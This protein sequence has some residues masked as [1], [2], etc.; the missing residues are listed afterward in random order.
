MNMK[1][2][3]S[4]L[5]ILTTTFCSIEAGFG[6]EKIEIQSSNPV[7]L[8]G[9]EEYQMGMTCL[10]DPLKKNQAF[11]Y[12]KAAVEKGSIRAHVMLG[13]CYLLG[14]GVKQNTEEGIHWIRTGAEL[15]DPNAQWT[16]GLYL[17]LGA[18]GFTSNPAEAF[19]WLKKAAEAGHINAQYKVG[20][21]Y[22]RG[23]GVAP[24]DKEAFFW[25]KKAAEQGYL[26]AQYKVAFFY[27]EG[28]G[29][30]QNVNE[31]ITWY[32]KAADLGDRASKMKLKELGQISSAQ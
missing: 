4:I 18:S 10:I 16:I 6:S 1:T 3:Y 25:Y 24:D 26:Y 21:C 7:V 22:E 31:A 17:K 28:R 2:F 29:T 20:L 27:E 14:I 23:E 8:P 11:P 19:Y 30:D 15:G 32:K 5:T 9:E 13:N 12:F